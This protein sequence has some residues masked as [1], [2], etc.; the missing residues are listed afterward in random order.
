MR[1]LRSRVQ[2]VTLYNQV[3]EDGAYIPQRYDVNSW[4]SLRL[5]RRGEHGRDAVKHGGDSVQGSYK[6]QI[7]EFCL[8]PGSTTISSV[9]V[10]HAYMFRQLELDPTVQYSMSSGSNCKSIPTLIHQF[11]ACLILQNSNNSSFCS[12]FYFKFSIS[13]LTELQFCPFIDLYPSMYEDWICPQSIIGVLYVLHVD[14]GE[15]GRG[16]RTHKELLNDSLLF[17]NAMYF[18][19][20]GNQQFGS[21]ELIPL[22]GFDDPTWPLL[23]MS[24][25]EAFRA[26]MR[27][28][29]L[30]SLKPST[31]SRQTHLQWFMPVPVMVDLFSEAPNICKTTTL[32]A[33]PKVSDSLL[34]SLMDDGWDIKETDKVDLIKCTVDRKSLVFKFHIGRST[35]Y[36][37]FQFNRQHF[38]G[39]EW[40]MMDQCGVVE[41]IKIP[42]EFQDLQG[43]IE[44]GR[45]WSLANVWHE[46][47]IALG[48][49]CP[50]EFSM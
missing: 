27:A 48:C 13:V 24:T 31:G 42:Y 32:F 45:D 6:A 9:R 1:P 38:N 10:Q 8:S 20:E 3:D 39:K 35:L 4:I 12:S 18:P 17:Y 7:K 16:S 50:N 40:K 21:L 15:L 26:R 28:D 36:A 11:L 23:D 29:F 41:V 34:S 5:E 49:N 25:S 19:R 44:V 22:P 43:E 2:A 37:N 14:I 30:S 33:F 47:S 46:L